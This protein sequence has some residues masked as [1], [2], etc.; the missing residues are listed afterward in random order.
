[1]VR[2]VAILRSVEILDD[3]EVDG[4]GVDVEVVVATDN[5]TK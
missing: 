4:V 5:G 2:I 1:M 3:I